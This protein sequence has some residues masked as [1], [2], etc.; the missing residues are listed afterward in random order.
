MPLRCRR[1]SSALKQT[2]LFKDYRGYYGMN[3]EALYKHPVVQYF[4]RLYNNMQDDSIGLIAAGVAF[5]FFLAAFP[6]LAALISIYGIFSDPA[7]V[8]NQLDLLNGLLPA[9]SLNIL[10]AQAESIASSSGAALGIGL[11]IG[12]FLTI[13]STT[14]GIKALVQGLNIAFNEKE[15]RNILILNGMAFSLTFMMMVYFLFSLSLVAIMPAVFTFLHFPETITTWLLLLRWPLLLFSANVGLQMIYYYA[16]SHTKKSW[17]WISC[18]SVSATLLWLVGCNLFSLFVLNFGN[19]NE[20][21]GSLG[22]V[23]ILLLW[24]WLSSLIVLMGAEINA[25]F[26][27]T[28]K[29]ITLKDAAPKDELSIAIDN[30]KAGAGTNKSIK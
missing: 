18:G 21:Y 26:R 25:A 2:E 8:R 30:P 19:Y 16:P 22:A 10:A 9:P 1:E 15:K 17:Q 6:A 29:Q 27:T 11:F 20:T 24:F 12:L 3:I 28:R 5:Y 13:Y 7:F 14:K 4:L 23:A